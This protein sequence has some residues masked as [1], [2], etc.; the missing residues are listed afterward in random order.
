MINLSLFVTLTFFI[1]FLDRSDTQPTRS[2][3]EAVPDPEG[4]HWVLG[5]VKTGNNAWA[6]AWVDTYM[7]VPLATSDS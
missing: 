7:E 5:G 1:E 6:V 2:R 3:W 4:T